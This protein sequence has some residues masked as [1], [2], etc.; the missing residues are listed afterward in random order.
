MMA[1]RTSP[2]LAASSRSVMGMVAALLLAAACTPPARS[3]APAGDDEVQAVVI[4]VAGALDG[5][6]G[7][8]GP[9]DIVVV[10]GIITGILPAGRG[11]GVV[12]DLGDAI[13]LP[14][15]IDTHVHLGWHFDREGRTQ[16]AEVEETA[17]ES[18][19]YGAE[20][21]LVTL[22]SGVTTVQSL[23]A[24][25]DK[26][27]RDAFARGI[28]PGPRVLTS[29]GAI[30]AWLGDDVNAYRTRV[31]ELAAAGADV[32]KIFASASIRDGGPPTLSQQQLDA[33]CGEASRLGLRT[34]AHAHG[35]ESARRA[36]LAGCTTIEHGALLDRETLELLAEHGMFYDPNI[37]LVFRNYFENQDRFLGVGNYTEE[38][39]DQMRAAVPKALAAFREALTVADLRVVFGTDAVAGAHG[40]NYQELVYRVE[41]GGQPAMD[42]IVSATSLAAE[43]L[44]LGA[45]IGT[46]AA[47]MRAD[48]IATTGNP[49]EDISAL[50]RVVFVMASGHV[51]RH[52][53]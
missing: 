37:D 4:R 9:S 47:G 31:Q 24:A 34:V 16:S 30:G 14:G 12:Y 13:A 43:S 27:L 5:T 3:Q 6:G 32:I 26:E 21:A 53:P 42:A 7:R 38:G 1:A 40:R 52:D 46:L 50:G 18:V 35:P 25:V 36:A 20:N 15:L 2:S 29:L 17:E 22:R 28:L 23:G 33:V 10:D 11:R 45:E 39:F 49:A 41:T 48:I 44:G 19:L 8:I 51:I